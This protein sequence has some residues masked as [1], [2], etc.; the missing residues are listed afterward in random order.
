[1]T[2]EKTVS[3]KTKYLRFLPA[4]LTLILSAS[5][6]SAGLAWTDIANPFLDVICCIASAMEWIITAIAVLIIALGG[7][8]W[9][10]SQDD[11]GKRN[12]AKTWVLHAIIALIIMMIILG[13]FIFDATGAIAQSCAG[14]TC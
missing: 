13:G 1:M 8:V 7:A 6:V 12:Q 10:Y 3:T 14:H 2:G 5:S 11:P 9:V 4:F